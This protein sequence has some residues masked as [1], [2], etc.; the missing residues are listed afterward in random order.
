MF[1][2]FKKKKL[3]EYTWKE[4][5]E[6]NNEKSCWLY[7][8]RNVYDVTSFLPRHPGGKDMILLMAGRDCTDLFIAYHPFTER[9]REVLKKFQIGVLKGDTEFGRYK[10]DS[11][12]YKTV[13]Q[14]VGKYF[15]DNK[16]DYKVTFVLKK[17]ANKYAKNI[18]T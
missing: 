14:R 10:A 13:R 3:K 17:K 12:F 8:D 16:L 1:Y 5:A 2:F 4:V 9:P 11:G 15:V 18:H 6:H 7:I